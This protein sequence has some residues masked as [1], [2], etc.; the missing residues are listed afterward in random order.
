MFY[1]LNDG[2]GLAKLENIESERQVAD[3]FTEALSPQAW[4]HALNLLHVQ[5]HTNTSAAKRA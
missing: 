3:I 2:N 5:R 4:Q 1:E